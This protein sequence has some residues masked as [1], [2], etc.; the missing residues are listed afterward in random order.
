[1]CSVSHYFSHVELKPHLIGPIANNGKFHS[2]IILHIE[3]CSL[4]VIGLWYE[5]TGFIVSL[6]CHLFRMK[7]IWASKKQPG[8][9]RDGNFPVFS[10][11]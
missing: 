5:M 6:L 2:E 8:R 3:I 9:H 4:L 11:C 1:M 10:S 7:Q